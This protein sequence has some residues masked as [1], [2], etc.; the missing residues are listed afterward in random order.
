[1]IIDHLHWGSPIPLLVLIDPDHPLHSK[2]HF[3]SS[4]IHKMQIDDDDHVPSD[5]G[6]NNVLSALSPPPIRTVHNVDAPF[7]FRNN[8][9]FDLCS[10]IVIV[11]DSDET[12]HGAPTVMLSFQS[13][14]PFSKE[15]VW[16]VS[17]EAVIH[18]VMVVVPCDNQV[19]GVVVAN[20]ED[21]DNGNNIDH[22]MDL[23]VMVEATGTVVRNESTSLQAVSPGICRPAE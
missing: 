13:V 9:A 17:V 7:P 15:A 20:N 23:F 11:N 4:P 14:L 1:M 10:A 18:N 21:H 6:N 12:V 19:E 2:C 16:E 3:L 5:R 22:K 8:L